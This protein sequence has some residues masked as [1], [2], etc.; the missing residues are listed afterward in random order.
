MYNGIKQRKFV[1]LLLF[2]SAFLSEKYTLV[3]LILFFS[4]D[5]DPVYLGEI[6]V[7]LFKSLV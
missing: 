2:F 3:Q 1:F 4:V 7:L 6:G 5:P